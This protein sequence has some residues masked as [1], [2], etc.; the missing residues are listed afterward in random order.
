M[1]SDRMDTDIL[2]GTEAGMKTILV[3]SAPRSR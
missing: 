3:L 1:V 2:A